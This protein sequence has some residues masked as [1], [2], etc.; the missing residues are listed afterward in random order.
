MRKRSSGGSWA[1][2]LVDRRR[3]CHGGMPKYCEAISFDLQYMKKQCALACERFRRVT[4]FFACE[5]H[6]SMPCPARGS[7]AWR[8]CA[9]GRW[10]NLNA[11]N[12]TILLTRL[13]CLAIV[14]P[15]ATR[16]VVRKQTKRSF[17]KAVQR[18][19]K[20]LNNT[21]FCKKC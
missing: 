6:A 4:V 12:C 17:V 10:R 15:L 3:G 7:G 16:R 13:G 21:Q 1:S 8:C 14:R 11:N 2:C 19:V 5:V 9:D 20:Q 18:V